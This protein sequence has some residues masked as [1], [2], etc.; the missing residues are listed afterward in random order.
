MRR[1]I[2]PWAATAAMALIAM[3]VGSATATED[4]APAQPTAPAAEPASPAPPAETAPPAAVPRPAIT[5]TATAPAEQ[6]TPPGKRNKLVRRVA[7]RG[8]LERSLENGT[9]PA[10]FRRYVPPEYRGYIPFDRR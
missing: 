8:D 10:R 6:A 7:R 1:I 4:A 9:V 5:P 3:T 2:D